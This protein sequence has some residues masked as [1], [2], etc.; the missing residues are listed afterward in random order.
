MISKGLN[1]ENV[2]LAGILN[3]DNMLNFPDFRAF[4]RSFQLMMQVSGR[5]GR[6]GRQGKVV[7]Q[8]S[9]PKHPVLLQVAAGDYDGM[10][11]LQIADRQT[12]AYPPFYR[13]IRLT[14][15]HKRKDVVHQA[16][17]EMA[18]CLTATFGSRVLGPDEPMIARIQTYYLE[19]ILLKI[20]KKASIQQAKKL[21]AGMIDQ[22]RAL[23]S[24]RSLQIIPDVDPM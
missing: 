24:Y 18:E 14:L 23:P 9:T 10:Y 4:E 20:E 16:A 21:L 3:A 6:F 13:L 19:N 1:F 7:I 5:A 2:Y 12:F 11:R 17:L 8:T 22:F 15:K